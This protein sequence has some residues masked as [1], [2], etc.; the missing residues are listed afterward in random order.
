MKKYLSLVGMVV[1]LVAL[2]AVA[3]APARAVYA[4]SRPTLAINEDNDHFFKLDASW[5][6]REGLVRYL[7]DVLQGP[8]THFVMCV[9]GQRTSYDSKTW[10]PIWA[11][12]DEPARRDTATAPDGTRD[13]WAVNA[14]ILFDKGIDPYEVWIGECRKKGVSPWVSIRM[15]D[16]HN[17]FMTNYFRNTTFSRTRRDLWRDPNATDDI[18]GHAFDFAHKEVRDYT[19]AQVAEMAERWDVDGIELDWMR[20]PLNLRAGRERED[21]HFLTEFMRQARE[22]VNAR[23]KGRKMRLAVRLPRSPQLAKLAGYEVDVWLRERLVDVVIGSSL[24]LPDPDLPVAEWREFVGFYNPEVVFLP[25]IDCFMLPDIAHF[26]GMAWR[27]QQGGAQGLYLFN[28]PYCGRYDT[29]GR[30]HDEDTFGIVCREGLAAETIKG[31]PKKLPPPKMDFPSF[32]AG[33]L[34][35]TSAEILLPPKAN[36][37]ELF[38]AKEL[39]EH[40]RKATGEEVK[41]VPSVTGTARWLFRLGRAAQIDRSGLDKNDATIRI[42]KGVVD[43]AGVDGEGAAMKASTPAGTLFGVYS[44]LERKLGVRWL[45]PGELGTFCP[46]MTDASFA[47]EQWTD[48]HLAFATWRANANVQSAGWKDK[49]AARKFY[50]NQSLWLRRHRFTMCDRLAKGH[51]F[52]SWFER[53]GKTHPEW[54]NEMPDGTRRGDPFYFGGRSDIISLCPSNPELVKEIV[55]QWAA[56]DPTDVINGNENDTAGKCCCANCLAADATGDDAGRHARAAA[57]FAAKSNGWWRALGSLST[58]YATFWKAI[59]EEGRKVRPDCRVIGC[60]YANYSDPPAPGTKLDASVILRF[61]PPVMYPWTDDKVKFFKDCW[62]GWSATGAKLM[63]RP[64]FTLDGHNFP[65]AYYRRYADCYDFVRAHGLVA[66]DLDSLTGVYG[67]NGLTLYVIASKNSSPERPLA[68]LETDYFN[69]FGSS[70][71]VVRACYAQFEKATEAGFAVADPDDTIEGGRYCD[72]ML[73]AYRVF[74][75]ALLE[76]ACAKL[77]TARA[78]ESDALVAQ[79]LAFVETGLRDALLVLKAQRGFATY[80]KTRDRRL[81]SEGY[82]EL[83]AFRK[84]NEGKGYLNLAT[85]DFYESRHW[86]RHLGMVSPE[87]REL[88][89]WELNL[90]PDPTAGTWVPQKELRHWRPDY[91]GIGWYRCRFK[92]TDEEARRFNRLVFGAVDGIPTVHLNGKVVQDGHPVK[93]PGE[94]W[95]TPFAVERVDAF[96]AGE[97]ELLIKIDKKVK[98]RRGIYRSVFIDAKPEE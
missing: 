78:A 35:K 85:V 84:N 17:T 42:G 65:L 27:Y 50:A 25:S 92:L 77:A 94:A 62:Q 52:T 24:F 38:A 41:N 91:N 70:A 48:R 2:G 82:A 8:V 40:W 60:V 31:K 49:A 18:Y 33:F 54:F 28:A 98:G 46:K 66:V 97:N 71:A 47:A 95:R 56:K 79:R 14:K 68:A 74:P 34:T 73:S 72:F 75:P 6:N 80:Q 26:R 9:N 57:A 39:A 44:F 20:F 89:G 29:D 11:G 3:E 36:G 5:M 12:L 87:A 16:I 51:A 90:N 55:R 58:R 37:V 22:T 76:D 69:A 19:L 30:K 1:G 13:K 10:E 96:K 86:P 63:M 4:K 23:Q 81:F 45:W 64:N 59:L 7:D 67:A 15:N 93:S 53:F 88:S 43:I 83:L 21:A 61:C 32:K